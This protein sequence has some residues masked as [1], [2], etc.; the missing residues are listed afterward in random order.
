MI[1]DFHA[2]RGHLRPE[3]FNADG[4]TPPPSRNKRVDVPFIGLLVVI[5]ALFLSAGTLVVTAVWHWLTPA[6]MHWLS[7]DQQSSL[8][9]LV[10]GAFAAACAWLAFAYKRADTPPHGAGPRPGMRRQPPS[11]VSNELTA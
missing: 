1:V 6:T 7:S 8:S 9:T 3:Q 2:A 11:A 4:G 10:I 5:Y